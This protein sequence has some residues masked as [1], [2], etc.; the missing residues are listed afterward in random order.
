MP[1]SLPRRV[2][3]ALLALAALRAVPALAADS[4]L[5]VH[6]DQVLRR[7]GGPLRAGV[8]L[9][10]VNHEV[11]GGIYSQ[12]IFGESFQE[13]ALSSA[14]K[15]F[16]AYGGAWHAGDGTLSVDGT[17]GPKCVSDAAPFA[18]GTVSVQMKFDDRTGENAG[19]VLRV[20]HP[21]MGADSFTGYEV[22][23]DP[24][25]QTVRLARHRDNYRLLQDTAATIPV[26]E[27]FPVEVRLAGGKIEV[28]ISGKT[29]VTVDDPAPF[30]AGTVGLRAWNKKASFRSLTVDRGAGAQ[31]LPFINADAAQGQV[32]GMWRP[33][34]TGDA[35][36]AFSLATESPFIGTQSQ[37]VEFKS[38]SGE[39]GI[40]NQ[41]LN[42]WGMSYLAGKPYDG[43]VWAKS[44]AATSL[45]VALQSTDGKTYAEQT[46]ALGAGDWRK[47]PFTLTSNATDPHGRFTLK[48]ERPGAVTLGHAFLQ[49]G[50]WGRFKDLPVR[51]DVALG[52]LAH[53]V[54]IMRYGGSMVNDN[55]YHWKQMIGPRDRRP[56]YHGNWYP[57]STNGFGVID[58]LNL[59]EAM[60]IEGIPDL[61]ANETPQDVA[62]FI[63]YVNGPADSEWGRR[64]AA[65]GHPAPYNLRRVELGNEERVDEAFARK[66]NALAQAVWAKDPNVI[67][68]AGDFSYHE[69]ITPDHVTH[70]DGGIRNLDGQ[71]DILRFA[72][73]HDREVWFDVHI[74][75]ESL[76]PS[77]NLRALPSYLDSMA[78][79]ANGAN[80]KVLCFE[81]NANSHG[82][83]RALANAM[84]TNVIRRD[85][86][87]P[88]VVSA[89]ALQPD[90]QN[91]NGWNQGLLFLNPSQVWLQP[92]AYVMQMQADD[93][94]ND[95]VQ[96][97]LTGA[98]ANHLDVTASKS[99]DGKTLT[100]QITN[101]G[102]ATTLALDLAHF[103]PTQPQAQVIQLAAPLNATNTAANPTD[104]TPTTTTWP[105]TGEHRLPA[106]SFTV[107]QLR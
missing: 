4:A 83:Q 9:E 31:P 101:L 28:S 20:S 5:T 33:I 39:V 95:L 27:W 49:P 94:P 103:T 10:D 38:G 46:L 29:V 93:L 17:D 34:T 54:G 16:R 58:F 48:L 21:R 97:T 43:Y 18:D 104:V 41:G 25:R 32:S 96:T 36:A 12:M 63:E 64:R 92:P 59:A 105:T 68:I 55:H 100:L 71:R 14:P 56:P 60:G 77:D 57:Y 30:P 99:P 73:D 45:T 75:S 44:D 47:L 53:R 88:I 90:G 79:V 85:G 82:I 74:W 61:N 6:A 50:P 107:V 7:P 81:L 69:P 70:A 80:F 84:S 42:R 2:T 76:A 62:D 8:C 23:L 91:D 22:S 52:L 15:D 67:P 40:E 72:K 89:N 35:A 87:L 106:H 102:E 78:Q 86:R 3:R 98:S 26:G 11:Y 1:N 19:L 37:R 13:P 66:F 24:A 51:K 65:D